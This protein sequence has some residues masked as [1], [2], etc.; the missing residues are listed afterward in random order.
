MKIDHYFWTFMTYS[1]NDSLLDNS[2]SGVKEWQMHHK[3][4]EK[5][6]FLK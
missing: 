2:Q 5:T 1:P 4:T 6:F 3:D